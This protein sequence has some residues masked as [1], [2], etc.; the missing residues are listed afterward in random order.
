MATLGLPFCFFLVRSMK[1]S[2]HEPSWG[3]VD[4][5]VLTWGPW[6]AAFAMLRDGI[7]VAGDILSP[8]KAVRSVGTCRF[9]LS[10][11]SPNPRLRGGCPDFIW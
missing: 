3:A 5:N 8:W 7:D 6:Q 11:R 4:V 2:S 9:I 10:G 1:G